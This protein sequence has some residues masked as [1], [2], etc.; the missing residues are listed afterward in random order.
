MVPGGVVRALVEG[1]KLAVNA[2]SGSCCQVSSLGV[3]YRIQVGRGQES[4]GRQ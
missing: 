2:Q 4:G 1:L 3:G